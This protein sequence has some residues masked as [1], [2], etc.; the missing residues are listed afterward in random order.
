M[1]SDIHFSCDIKDCEGIQ[2]ANFNN[3]YESW[4]QL[5]D[6]F[7]KADWRIEMN[8]SKIEKCFCPKHNK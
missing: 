3:L 6:T 2:S 8:G 1:V 5:I 7:L 4:G